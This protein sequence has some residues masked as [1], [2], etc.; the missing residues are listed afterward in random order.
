M[1][2]SFFSL[3][4]VGRDRNLRQLC[5]ARSQRDNFVIIIPAIKKQN[6]KKERKYQLTRARNDA[7]KLK[8]S[9]CHVHR[10]TFP[11]LFLFLSSSLSLSLRYSP[12]SVERTR[13]FYYPA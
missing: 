8:C 1:P 11:H 3:S 4:S 9:P 5:E 7:R 13:L 6:Q 10:L 2:A 12:S